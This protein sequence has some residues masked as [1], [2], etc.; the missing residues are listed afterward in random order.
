MP[1]IHERSNMADTMYKGVVRD[2]NNEVVYESDPT[3]DKAE[4]R[5]KATTWMRSWGQQMPGA[6]RV[7]VVVYRGE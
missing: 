5:K 1:E 4:A 6:M 3:T 2:R 7:S